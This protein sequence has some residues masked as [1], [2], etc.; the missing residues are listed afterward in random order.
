[1][2]LTLISAI[3]TMG[4]AVAVLLIDSFIIGMV[5]ATLCHSL[6]YV[7][8]PEPAVAAAPVA[9]PA[10]A[11]ND[12]AAMRAT[13]IVMPVYLL[14]LTNPSFFGSRLRLELGLELQLGL[15]IATNL[16]MFFLW[17]LLFGIYFSSKL[18]Q[19]IPSRYPASFWSNVAITA[20]ILLGSAV[21]DADS[22][23]DVFQAFSVRMSL[24]VAVT[25]YAWGA[26]LVLEWWRA[27]RVRRGQLT[28][29]PRAA[30]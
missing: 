16:W 20:L 15:G 11:Q 6:A 14:A 21:Q 3:G 28:P 2:G 17:I 25:V 27:R 19:V 10:P 7:V 4:W 13:L 22:G 18:Y 1:M 9:Q 23:K 29:A 24:F 30:S 26:V 8:F 5:L 12:R